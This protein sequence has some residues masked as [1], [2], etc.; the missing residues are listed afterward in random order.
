MLA[1]CNS[2]TTPTQVSKMAVRIGTACITCGACVWECPAEAISP[3][4]PRPIV[5]PNLCTECYGFFGESQ[6]IIVCPANAIAV[7][8]ETVEQL[9]NRYNTLAQ[10]RAP[11]DTWIWRR[12][13]VREGSE[14]CATPPGDPA[15]ANGMK[16]AE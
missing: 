5:E 1:S 12:I 15:C 16:V 10:G 11:Q 4:D 6:C 8:V 2:S 3:G 7:D 9:Q 14:V 13:E